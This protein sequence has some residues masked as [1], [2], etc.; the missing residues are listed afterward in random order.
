M[1]RRQ[2]VSLTDDLDGSKAVETIRFGLDG[3]SYEIDLNRKHAGNLRKSLGEF[4]EHGRKAQPAQ[5]AQPAR[6]RN[7]K[8]TNKN[9]LPKAAVVRS[10]A[11]ANGITV[12]TRG[13]VPADVVEKYQRSQL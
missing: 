12:S 9:G 10:W 13:R 3:I 1:A 5:P 7:A 4:V 2:S 8:P 11:A 6:P